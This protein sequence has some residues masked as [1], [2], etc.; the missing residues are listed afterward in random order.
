MAPDAKNNVPNRPVV[1]RSFDSQLDRQ[2]RRLSGRVELRNNEA[3]S[4][5]MVLILVIK[6]VRSLGF[7]PQADRP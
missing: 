5:L 7:N 1:N 6:K 4:V 3:G 2:A